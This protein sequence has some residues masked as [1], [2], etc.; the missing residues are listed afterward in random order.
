MARTPSSGS[1]AYSICPAVATARSRPTRRSTRCSAIAIPDDSPYSVGGLGL[2]GTKPGQE[3]LESCDT[4]LIVGSSFPYVEFYPEPG[5]ARA[6]Q[7]DQEDALP[8]AEQEA[9]IGHVEA[10]GRPEHE[11]PAVRVAVGALARSGGADR[12]AWSYFLPRLGPGPISQ[13]VTFETAT[14][15]EPPALWPGH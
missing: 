13:R 3:A 6:V 15:P 14:G 12:R 9:A 7:L 11:R 2:L 8:P 1:H 10:D 5:K 4:L